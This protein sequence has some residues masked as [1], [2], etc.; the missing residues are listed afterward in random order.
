MLLLLLLLLLLT[1]PLLHLQLLLRL[2]C[3]P[4]LC[5]ETHNGRGECRNVV[6]QCRRGD[7]GRCFVCV[8][9]MLR[10]LSKH[11]A[12]LFSVH[13]RSHDDGISTH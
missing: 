9:V 5:G 12:V 7:C 10:Y 4:D 1:A 2:L 11:A 3:A 6:S 8:C 13:T